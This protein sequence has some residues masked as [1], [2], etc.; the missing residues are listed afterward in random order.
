MKNQIKKITIATLL[1]TLLMKTNTLHALTKDETIYA[2][3]KNNGE[4][5]NLF[6]N[7]HL[8]N[9]EKLDELKDITELTNIFNINGTETFSKNG[10]EIIWEADGKDIYYQ[11]NSQ[12]DL[13]V[14][15][16]A[17]Y[18]L[19][20]QEIKVSEL[21]GKSGNVKI[22]LKY[23]NL[24]KHTVKINGK[25][26]NLY[27]PFIVTTGLILNSNN[28]DIQVNNGK[29]INTGKNNII[30]GL[31]TPGLYES[32]K[33]NELQKMDEITITFKTT[34]FELPNIYAVITPKLIDEEDLKIFNKINGLYTNIDTLKTSIDEI[35]K[36][37][38][39]L[40][41][42]SYKIYE[43]TN[44][45]S[46]NLETVV[47]KLEELQRG[48]IKIDEGLKLILQNLNDTKNML[49][50]LNINEINKL[51]TANENIINNTQDNNIKM[52]LTQNNEVLTKIL[53]LSNNIDGVIKLLEQALTELEIG[54][55]QISDGTNTIKEGVKILSTK[56]KELM[57]GT[58]TLYE[59]NVALTNGISKY[60]KEG[61]T[62]MHTI[63][64]TDLKNTQK[65][66][67]ALINLGENYNSFTMNNNNI[68]SETKFI[69]TIPSE[70]HE[71]TKIIT[72]TKP[73]TENLWTR[74]KNL[75][76]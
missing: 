67:E 11:G 21:I 68:K 8:T 52:L 51:I 18:Y 24:D 40:V 7:V 41:E 20:N 38:N 14:T 72:K 36:G 10:N 9:E 33:L 1:L 12:K 37:A 60:N 46:T 53:N 74:I 4:I 73:K 64:N 16:T 22:T 47:E 48:T 61:I 50:A 42:G 23:T 45:I 75:F 19:E 57:A 3:L 28:Q 5:N 39:N 13:P 62:K 70:K 65:R 69:L 17:K 54:S 55:K 49:S 71:E 66:I 29:I 31:S 6:A 2:K 26:E 56:T 35:E 59:G 34:K 30:V 27:T 44:L 63:I 25:N 58:K 15:L 43:G 32:L 76:K